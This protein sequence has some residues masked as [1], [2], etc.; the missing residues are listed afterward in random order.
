MAAGVPVALP[1]T[2]AFPE[3]VEA[4]GGGVLCPAGDR[5][6]LAEA[7]EDLLLNPDHARAL[8]Q[9]GRRSVF[10]K[11][12]SQAM[13]QATL[14]MFSEAVSARRGVARSGR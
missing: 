6:G 11:F 5:L 13:G 8:G 1:R 7:V 3:L 14:K 4:T 9:A 2:G 10:E 12:S